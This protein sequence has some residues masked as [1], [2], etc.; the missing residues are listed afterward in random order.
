[1]GELSVSPRSIAA[2]H[3]ALTGLDPASVRA[4]AAAAE[5]APTVAAVR[6]IAAGL[7]SAGSIEARIAG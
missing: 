3:A 1:V 7:R 6:A 4:A 5:L 2:V